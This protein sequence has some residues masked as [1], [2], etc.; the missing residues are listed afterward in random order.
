MSTAVDQF[1]T[2]ARFVAAKLE[3]KDLTDEDVRVMWAQ[4]P[5]AIQESLKK[6]AKIEAAAQTRKAF[7]NF[8][9]EHRPQAE[10]PDKKEI[11]RKA[12]EEWKSLSAE[13]KNA[14]AQKSSAPKSK[15]RKQSKAPP[16]DE[17]GPE[18]QAAPLPWTTK[19]AEE[20]FNFNH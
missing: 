20:P 4:L 12:R 19:T 6:V 9:K 8:A 17:A 3:H 10:H 7:E 15:K 1:S 11:N 14:Y 18:A 5:E 13:Q 2:L 16:S